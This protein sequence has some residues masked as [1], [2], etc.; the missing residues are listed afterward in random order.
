M[1]VIILT[2]FVMLLSINHHI[3]YFCTNEPTPEYDIDRNKEYMKAKT[4]T[5]LFIYPFAYD[6]FIHSDKQT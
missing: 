4:H 2:D 3:A 5:I 6:L 1:L